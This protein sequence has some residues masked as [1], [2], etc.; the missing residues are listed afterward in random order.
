MRWLLLFLLAWPSGACHAGTLRPFQGDAVEGR[1]GLD[2]GGFTL[3]EKGATTR[4]DL[5]AVR[6][7]VFRPAPE[8]LPGVSPKG[9]FLTD[10]SF[11]AGPVIP[12]DALSVRA[13]FSGIAVPVSAVARMIFVPLQL[14]KALQAAR[15]KTGALLARGDFFEGAFKGF[16]QESV[17]IDSAIFGPQ[18]FFMRSQAA[19]VIV[20]DAHPKPARYEVLAREGSDFLADEVTLAPDGVLLRNALAG[21]VK[22]KMDDLLEIRATSAPK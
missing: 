17:V 1:V 21:E 16:K 18:R 11:L 7:A 2:N 20:A 19:A 9:I 14:E 5:A 22:V 12:L 13:G 6:D 15:G 4:F 8:R 3:T 10:G